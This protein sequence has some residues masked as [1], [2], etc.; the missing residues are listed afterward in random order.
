MK[1]CVAHHHHACECREEMF[2]QALEVLQRLH[3]YSAPPACKYRDEYLQ[4]MA[5]A[6]EVLHKAREVGRS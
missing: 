1:E 3:H 4:A 6:V 2:R 5:D